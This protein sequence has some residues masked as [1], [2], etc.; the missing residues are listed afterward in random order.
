MT[1]RTLQSLTIRD[2]AKVSKKIESFI[3]SY[4]S[5]GRASGV[6]IGLSGGLDSSV[7]LKLAANAL[8]SKRVFGLM[9]PGEST[10]Q[11]DANDAVALARDL[12]VKYSLVNIASL[13]SKFI[14]LHPGGNKKLTGNMTARL[15]MIALYRQAALSN[16]FVCGTSDKSELSIGY[17]TKYGDG[18]SDL[19]PLAGLYKTQVR[20]LG[21]H[22]KL[23]IA[24]LNKKSSPRLWKGHLAEAELGLSYEVI[25]P[26]LHLLEK[27]LT[28]LQISNMLNQSK[29]TVLKIRSRLQ[30][31]V[32]KRMMPAIPKV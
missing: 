3:S 23:P 25:D 24:I 8:G 7:T 20:E 4:I 22:L 32:H 29:D 16:Y 2:Y 9:L 27:K 1:E 6:V 13:V 17:F 15:R 18:A 11:Q 30:S 5:A 10:P 19:M 14:Q 26:I 21:R 28:V 31:S 12:N